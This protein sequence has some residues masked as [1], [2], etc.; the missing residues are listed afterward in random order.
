MVNESENKFLFRK[1]VYSED[2]GEIQAKKE[3]KELELSQKQ[4]KNLWYENERNKRLIISLQKDI[5]KFNQ[6]NFKEKFKQLKKEKKQLKECTGTFM[7][8]G[9][10]LNNMEKD[11]HYM[12]RELCGELC[13]DVKNLN[14]CLFF[15]EKYKVI[16]IERPKMG[17]LI[18]R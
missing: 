17:G 4:F 2:K 7:H 18:R 3:I 16:N 13:M 11:K 1:K 10:I 15:L 8:L 6:E 9:R 14:D 5:E 12:V